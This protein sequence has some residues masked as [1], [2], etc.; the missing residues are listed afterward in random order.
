MMLRLKVT[1]RELRQYQK[2]RLKRCNPKTVTNLTKWLSRQARGKRIPRARISADAAAV[3]HL[4]LRA[5]NAVYR[6]RPP[7]RYFDA[8]EKILSPYNSQVVRQADPLGMAL[9][10]VFRGSSFRCGFQ[11]IFYVA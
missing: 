1:E 5:R 8:A 7:D 6:K 4:G 11:N 2:K 9:G 10:V 3:M